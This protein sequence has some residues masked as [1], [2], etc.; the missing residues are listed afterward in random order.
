MH[1]SRLDNALVDGILLFVY[2]VVDFVHLMATC[3]W[4]RSMMRSSEIWKFRTLDLCYVQTCFGCGRSPIPFVAHAKI[5]DTF[6]L[7]SISLHITYDQLPKCIATFAGKMIHRLHIRF[8]NG[9]STP[10]APMDFDSIVQH[11]E[12][13][14]RL[15]G[16]EYLSI[17]NWPV[18]NV[19]DTTVKR[20]PVVEPLL[21]R[22]GGGLKVIKFMDIIPYD[23]FESITL[24]CPCIEE[25][26]I[27]G[28]M[29]SSV[30]ALKDLGPKYNRQQ[31][32][33]NPNSSEIEVNLITAIKQPHVLHS[34]VHLNSVSLIN[35]QLLLTPNLS[36]FQPHL[37]KFEYIIQREYLAFVHSNEL[38]EKIAYLPT[39]LEELTFNIDCAFCNRILQ[40]IGK[41]FPALTSLKIHFEDSIWVNR[42]VQVQNNLTT[43]PA[44]PTNN[45]LTVPT[46][47]S[48]ADVEKYVD[49]V[50]MEQFVQGCKRLKVLEITGYPIQ[51]S[52]LALQMIADLRHLEKLTIPYSGL[53]VSNLCGDLPRVLARCEYLQ[54]LTLD[55]D[56]FS[57]I[58]QLSSVKQ[59]V[60][61]ERINSHLMQLAEQF[62]MIT[63][64]FGQGFW[65]S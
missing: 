21:E 41:L 33:N 31:I 1:L 30:V 35:T 9:S 49:H 23:F 24:Y 6:P 22:I 52:F 65:T 63:I 48:G 4:L 62:P 13:C 36:L 19:I 50:M 5:C 16:I 26:E 60:W 25:I 38:L 43:W 46:A 34:L 8:A 12:E 32:I 47:S 59:N 27:E 53:Q 56:E 29:W 7:R 18:S 57:K 11:F 15:E 20:I 37:K 39:S 14:P 2:N 3:K 54:E 17:T 55:N 51:F 61:K 42:H 44:A 64:K 28:K 58:A 40:H 10:L 45:T